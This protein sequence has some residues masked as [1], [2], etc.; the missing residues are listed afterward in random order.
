MEFTTSYILSQIFSTIAY[1]L[2]GSTYFLKNRKTILAVSFFQSILLIIGYWFLGQ[3][4]GMVMV[5]VGILT[6]IMFFVDEQKNGK[7]NKIE[8]KDVIML[9]IILA[10]T[11]ILTYVTYTNLLSL[12]SVLGTIAWLFSVWLKD[13]KIYKIISIP[14]ALFWLGFN[15]YANSISGIITEIILVIVAVCGLVLHIKNENKN[16]KKMEEEKVEIQQ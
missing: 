13:V 3:Y 11:A 10:Y 5:T 9:T 6:N 15:I 16:I 1:I 7:S 8:K 2:L 12:L 4:Q 14:T